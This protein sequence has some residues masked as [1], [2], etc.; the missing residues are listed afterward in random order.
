MTFQA[1]PSGKDL[2]SA[3]DAVLDLLE[4]RDRVGAGRLV[5]RHHGR[6]AAVQP[7]LAVEIG[8][9]EFDPGDVAEAQHGAVR[10]RAQDDVRGTAPGEVS[11]PWVWMLSWSC[12]S[13]EIGRAPIRPTGACTFCAWIAS[14]TSLVVRL[15]PGELV[16]P[17]PGPH[18]VILRPPQGRV[19][20]AG[21]ALDAVEQIDRDVVRDEERVLDALGRVDRQHAEQ[22]GGLLLD[23][24]ALLANVLGQLGQGDLDP[25][26][27]VDG[28]DVRIGAEFER[29]GERVAAVV[30]AD[31]LHV[32][33]LVDAHD[34]RLDGLG[35]RGFHH[36]GRGAGI[37]RRHRDLRR[38][39][40]GV[41]R[42]RDGEQRQRTGDRRDDRD[43][44]RQARSVD[45]DR[46][47]H[48]LRSRWPTGRSG[49]P[50]RRSR[51]AP[52]A[53]HRR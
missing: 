25:V 47:E 7:G 20:D 28:V 36:L 30:A 42:D 12:C 48:G 37:G 5:D 14:I 1:R 51:A 18:R 17:D 4:G 49:S 39:D 44:D 26:V 45:E 22:R 53:G 46:G 21:R 29:P 24:D 15:R 8:R 13:L 3:R 19:A 35:D 34:L 33:H 11:R 50:A 40:V 31:A 43:D 32:D 2:A 9:A 38:H 41:L 52:A 10:V 16:G 23:R 6:R 27:D